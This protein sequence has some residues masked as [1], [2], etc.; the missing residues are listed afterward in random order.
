MLIFPQ[1]TDL[2]CQRQRALLVTLLLGLPGD[3]P[4][5]QIVE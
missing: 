2:R 4:C 1:V 5:G 3:V